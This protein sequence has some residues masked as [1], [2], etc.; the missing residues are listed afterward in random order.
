M[1][2]P[3]PPPDTPRDIPVL[4]VEDSL[5]QAFVLKKL[6]EEHG[7]RPVLAV[8]GREGLEMLERTPIR[9]VISDIDMPEM[10]GYEMCRT[11][12]HDARHRLIPVILLTTLSDVENIVLGLQAHA[13]YYFTK[14][15]H[16][17]LLLAR[18]RALLDRPTE[19]LDF[20]PEPALTVNLRG[21]EHVITANRRQMLNL[22]L[23]TYDNA[24]QQN[25]ELT[26]TQSELNQRNQQLREQSHR[27]EISERNFRAVLEN[28]V[29]GMVVADGQGKMRFLNPAAKAL[30]DTADAAALGHCF[31]FAITAGESREFEIAV[32]GRAPV[33]VEQRVVETAWEGDSALLVSLRDITRRKHDERMI[34]EQQEK[35]RQA[36]LQLQA[37]A[38]TDGLTGLK[39]HRS[40]KERL[41]EEFQRATRYHQTLSLV[42]LDVD[43][44]KQFNDTY[45]HPEGDEV[46]RTVARVLLANTRTTDL[47][48]RYG[49]EEFVVLLPLTSLDDAAEMAERL[50]RALAETAWPHRSIT[51]S[52]GVATRSAD[53]PDAAALTAH[54]DEAL[55]RSKQ[56]GR[57]RVTIAGEST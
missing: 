21:K 18:V 34:Q 53:T 22:L 26:R 55:Y 2:P 41:E 30:L 25:R 24:V 35:L 47:V 36:N 5:P 8:H 37:L 33:I 15:Y 54:A 51:A 48:A 40:F 4:V 16:P 38:T 10:N 13:D 17:R 49:G 19:P 32:P 44:F 45:G 56:R 27:L 12:K 57:D 6:L 23:S 28:N 3:Q 7:Y 39:N 52:F 50:R 11:I 14:P 46:L 31:P 20:A 9:M 29:D 1:E 43:R 42:L